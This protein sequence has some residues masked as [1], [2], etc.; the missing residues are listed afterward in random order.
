MIRVA[1]ADD[2]AFTCRLLASCVDDGGDGEVVA[3]ANDAR[4]KVDVVAP[5]ERIG[6]RLAG[7]GKP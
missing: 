3:V 2:S 6:E 5:P 1:I 7:R 4:T